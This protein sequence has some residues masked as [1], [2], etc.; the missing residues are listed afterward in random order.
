MADK[1]KK[2]TICSAC[3][4]YQALRSEEKRVFRYEKSEAQLPLTPR[5]RDLAIFVASTTTTTTTTNGHDR[6]LY[7][8]CACAR[9]VITRCITTYALYCY[10][11]CGW[12]LVSTIHVC[13]ESDVIS[14]AQRTS[15]N[16]ISL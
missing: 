7:P 1:K 10:N 6:L 4:A 13:I 12:G 5:T 8:C 14:S 3:G 15:K 2:S 11:L 16:F 9:G